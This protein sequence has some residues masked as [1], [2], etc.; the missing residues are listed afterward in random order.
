M[1]ADA[2]TRPGDLVEHARAVLDRRHPLPVLQV[3]R[4]AALLARQALEDVV[5]QLCGQH[6]DDLA[7][8]TMRSRLICLRQLADTEVA[9]QASAAWAGLS[10]VCHY[11][12]YELTPTAGEVRHLIDGVAWLVGNCR[13]GRA[14]NTEPGS[15]NHDE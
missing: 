13:V 3:H 10:A 8:A 2:T 6:G 4:A 14:S 11:H 7:A 12:A 9:E 1:S 15:R 5:T